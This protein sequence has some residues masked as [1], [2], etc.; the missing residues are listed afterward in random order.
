[1]NYT[2]T[3]T[4]VNLNSA[5]VRKLWWKIR[6]ISINRTLPSVRALPG[7]LSL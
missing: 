3:Y 1:M 2:N 4:K 5:L 6:I 7:K